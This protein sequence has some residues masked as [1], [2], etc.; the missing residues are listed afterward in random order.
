MG[1]GRER[2]SVTGDKKSRYKVK[3][4]DQEENKVDPTD[5]QGKQC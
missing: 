4:Q 2:K 1:V 5:G 3:L